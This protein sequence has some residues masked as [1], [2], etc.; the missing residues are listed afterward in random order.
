MMIEA[1]PN[2]PMGLPIA[3]PPRLSGQMRER[4]APHSDEGFELR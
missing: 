3:S 4:Y 1:L 2:T